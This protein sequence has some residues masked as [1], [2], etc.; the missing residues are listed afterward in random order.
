MGKAFSPK[1]GLVFAVHGASAPPPHPRP[2]APA[3]PFFLGGGG[4]FTENPWG[5]GGSSRRGEGEEGPGVCTGNFVG[6]GERA[7]RAP[8]PIYRE[9]QP[10]FRRKRLG[11]LTSPGISH[12]KTFLQTQIY[13]FPM[14]WPFQDHGLEKA[15]CMK[16]FLCLERPFLDLV[17]QTPRP[18]AGVDPCLLNVCFRLLFPS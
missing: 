18:R 7:P 5:G 16:D 15:L 13:P 10:P 12:P 8:S 14:A 4:G 6:G 9:N 1:K 11:S 2:L 3:P 17:S